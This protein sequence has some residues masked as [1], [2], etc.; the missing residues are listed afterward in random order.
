MAVMTPSIRRVQRSHS[1]DGQFVGRPGGPMGALTVVLLPLAVVACAPT[2]DWR[3]VR[4]AGSQLL[5]MFPCKPTSQ[6]RQVLL[7]GQTVSMVVHACRAGEVTWALAQTDVGDP[8]RV[9]PVMAELRVAAQTKMGAPTQAW[10]ALPSAIGATPNVQSGQASFAT[11]GPA[12][13]FA[14]GTWVFQASVLGAVI[15]AEGLGNYFGSLRLP[16]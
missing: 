8:A 3:E 5:L 6:A 16:R 10:Q 15:P 2:L 1:I 4:P 9:G 12:G 11:V 14:H 13:L 7:A